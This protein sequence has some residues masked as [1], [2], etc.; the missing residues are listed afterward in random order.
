M[1]RYI[2]LDGKKYAVEMGS[3][4]RRWARSFSSD[5]VASIVRL[6]FVDRGPGLR[7]YTMALLLN[8]WDTDTDIYTDGVTE[9]LDQQRA[10]LE[11]SYGKISTPIQFIDPFG[12]VPGAGGV[13]FTSL[14]Q[15][16]PAYSTVLKP[17]V[18]MEIELT[19]A[20]QVVA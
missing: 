7:V 5:L 8:S 6:N 19:E 18:R 17:Y 4:T 20:T 12:E 14:N 9:T 1:N 15:V 11:T 3:Y 13:Y 2:T 16:I 10:N